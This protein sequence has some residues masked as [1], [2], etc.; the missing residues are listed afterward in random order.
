MTHTGYVDERA[1]ALALSITCLVGDHSNYVFIQIISYCFPS[2]LLPH[3]AVFR[4]SNC[5]PFNYK[6]DVKYFFQFRLF[7][8]QI[9]W[10]LLTMR[11]LIIQLSGYLCLL[12]HMYN[13]MYNILKGQFSNIT[14]QKQCT[15]FLNNYFNCIN[16]LN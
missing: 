16:K 2:F 6:T 5:D 14:C 9:L 13:M 4:T 15:S 12:G 11:G 7:F 1:I 8:K 10:T 3:L